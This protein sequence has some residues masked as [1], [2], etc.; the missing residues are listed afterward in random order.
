MIIC[1]IVCNEILLRF[2][3]RV[4]FAEAVQRAKQALRDAGSVR[5]VMHFV[6]GWSSSPIKQVTSRV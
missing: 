3:N 5:V 2:K 4:N 1:I 6:I